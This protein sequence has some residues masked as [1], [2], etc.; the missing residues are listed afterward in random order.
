MNNEQLRIK[1]LVPMNRDVAKPPFS[2]GN[3]TNSHACLLVGKSTVN[4]QTPQNDR[5]K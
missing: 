1:N 4:Q 3:K 5:E 2:V